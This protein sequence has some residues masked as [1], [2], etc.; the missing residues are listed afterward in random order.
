M[1][2]SAARSRGPVLVLVRHGRTAWNAEGRFLGHTDLP[3]DDEGLAA[4]TLLGARLR[5][6]FDAIY[7]SP[8]RRA[9]QTAESLGPVDGLIPGISEL[10]QGVLEGLKMEEGLARHA[11]YFE[12]W[13]R[14][15]GSARVPGGGESL[16]D[17]LERALPALEGLVRSHPTSTIAVVTHQMVIA[18]VCCAASGSPLSDYR[19]WTVP[20]LAQTVLTWDGRQLVCEAPCLGVANGRRTV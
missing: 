14:D 9:V 3:L 19:R 8:L 2:W 15:P 13:A 7:S 11:A 18:A 16:G 10:R 4:A 12:Q 6:Q 20:N 17:V 1:P 5:G